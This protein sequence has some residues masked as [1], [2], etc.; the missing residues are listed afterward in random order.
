M[1]KTLI[2]SVLFIILFGLSCQRNTDK[3]TRG[4]GVYPGR[5]SEDFSPKLVP[6]KTYRNIARLRP[7]YQSSAYDYNLTSQLLTDG[8]ISREMP[9]YISV[10][11][12]KGP[13]AKNERE[14]LFDDKPVSAMV[15]DGTDI[16]IQLEIGGEEA[17]DTIEKIILTGTLEFLEKETTWL[18]FYMFR[19]R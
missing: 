4:T 15:L 9:V 5:P 2:F 3:Y 18:D 14:W 11:T 17:S 6:A 1:K 8:I 7:A 13:V 12:N 10:S 16:S 19:I